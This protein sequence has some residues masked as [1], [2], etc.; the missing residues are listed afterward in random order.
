MIML[1]CRR[2]RYF[3]IYG[4]CLHYY[5]DADK[6]DLKGTVPLID[7]TIA[8]SIKADDDKFGFQINQPGSDLRAYLLC[9][10]TKEER[11]QWI[12]ALQLAARGP[13]EP[14]EP[15]D[16]RAEAAEAENARLNASLLKAIRDQDDLRATN[17]LLNMKLKEAVENRDEAS[18]QANQM[19]SQHSA[20]CNEI[21]Q[22]KRRHTEEQTKELTDKIDLLNDELEECQ[23]EVTR[24][25]KQKSTLTASLEDVQRRLEASQQQVDS[26]TAALAQ[27]E[28][29][30]SD[31]ISSLNAQHESQLAAQVAAS[32]A[33]LSQCKSDF[34]SKLVVAAAEAQQWI[35]QAT[36]ESERVIAE[37]SATFQ[38]Q[39][40]EQKELLE[41]VSS[42]NRSST[43]ENRKLKMELESLQIMQQSSGKKHADAL[44]ALDQELTEARNIQENV[45]SAQRAEAAENRKLRIELEALKQQLAQKQ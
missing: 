34:E 37:N 1:I 15:D 4:Y 26:L 45:A 23:N 27:L 2:K 22:L 13:P 19:Q 6:S 21:E 44:A 36:A 11:A 40:D 35:A 43:A 30:K 39:L 9:A 32:E 8:V 5:T 33:A 38:R 25:N 18:A 24:C 28:Q 31:Q 7:C 3:E 41:S 29:S 14:I 10:D 16:S 17:E 12:E 20:L 42:A